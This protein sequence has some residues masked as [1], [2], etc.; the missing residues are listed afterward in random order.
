LDERGPVRMCRGPGAL[1]LGGVRHSTGASQLQQLTDRIATR[2]SSVVAVVYGHAL[3]SL[4]VCLIHSRPGVSGDIV[5][6]TSRNA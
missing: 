4:T 5:W 6:N 1:H 2:I 3:S